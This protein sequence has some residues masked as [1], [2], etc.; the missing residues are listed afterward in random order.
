MLNEREKNQENMR[1]EIR[2]NLHEI[3]SPFK[4]IRRLPLKS[5]ALFVVVV[6]VCHTIVTPRSTI[7]ESEFALIILSGKKF[8]DNFKVALV[9]GVVCASLKK[10]SFEC[11]TASATNCNFQSFSTFDV[12]F[13]RNKFKRRR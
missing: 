5:Y 10:K 13:R 11:V 7:S 4:V 1:N 6:G 9:G 12:V 3:D 2:F 8:T